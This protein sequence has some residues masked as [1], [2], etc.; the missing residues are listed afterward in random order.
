MSFKRPD[1]VILLNDEERKELVKENDDLCVISRERY[2]FRAV[3]PLPVKNWEIPYQIGIWVE[4][5]EKDYRRV[6]DRWEDPDQDQEPLFDATIAND[7][8]SF[9]PTCGLQVKLQLTGPTSRP[10]IVISPSTHP[11]HQEQCQGITAHRAAEYS[12]Y[13]A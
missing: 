6:V 4:V 8:P 11:L 3:L 7:I 13:F 10:S 12:E 2:F 5:N 1:A 9:D